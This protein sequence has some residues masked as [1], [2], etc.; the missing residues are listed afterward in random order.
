VRG[1][2]QLATGAGQNHVPLGGF[3]TSNEEPTVIQIA[4]SQSNNEFVNIY[5]LEYNEQLQ[6][7]ASSSSQ[8]SEGLADGDTD[9]D[10][11]YQRHHKPR[12]SLF[13]SD[14]LQF[15]G[16]TIGLEKPQSCIVFMRGWLTMNWINNIGARHVVDPEFWARHLDF[17]PADD[18]S[19]NFS[20]PP[21]PSTSWHLMALPVITIGTRRTQ[22]GKTDLEKIANLRAQAANAL[23]E[24]HHQVSKLASSGMSLGDSM[25]RDF[26]VFDETHFAVEQKISVCMQTN[27]DGNIF[28]RKYYP[29]LPCTL[30]STDTFAKSSFGLT[31]AAIIRTSLQ[32]GN[33]SQCHGLYILLTRTFSQRSG[34]NTL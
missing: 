33:R 32:T 24:H 27:D 13:F 9:P 6:T 22:K 16:H 10:S 1:Y 3:L 25:I 11:S 18:N 28:S 23:K 12:K 7:L 26:H 21:L 4:S 20:V 19:N 30:T 29:I 8:T 17:R 14:P 5:P 15:Y 2:S 34:T 31:Q